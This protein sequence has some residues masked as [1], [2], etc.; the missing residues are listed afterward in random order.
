M[1]LRVTFADESQAQEAYKAAERTLGF[2]E[3]LGGFLRRSSDGFHSYV[4]EISLKQR[5]LLVSSVWPTLN[6]ISANRQGYDDKNFERC[7][8]L[9]KEVIALIETKGEIII[10]SAPYKGFKIGI[11]VVVSIAI[12]VA[13][14]SIVTSLTR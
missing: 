11:I 4:D 14:A 12:I 3:T 8:K 9:A 1:R 6:Y 7:L 13:T 10:E 5:S 2:H